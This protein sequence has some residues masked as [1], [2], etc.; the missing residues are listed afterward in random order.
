MAVIAADS[1]LA[2]TDCLAIPARIREALALLLQA[3][4]DAAELRQD[5]WYFSVDLHIL[6]PQT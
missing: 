5:V 3:S 4:K 6:R 2:E 1:R